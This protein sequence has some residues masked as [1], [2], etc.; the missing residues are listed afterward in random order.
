ML[1]KIFTIIMCAIVICLL[2][3]GT[4]AYEGK[5]IFVDGKSLDLNEYGREV[6]GETYVDIN[7]FCWDIGARWVAI[8]PNE[9][10]VRISVEDM[11]ISFHVDDPY[12]VA[13]GR[14]L[15][16]N[17]GCY[18]EGERVFLPLELLCR[19]FGWENTWDA[20]NCREAL[21]PTGQTLEA[22]DTYYDEEDL[23]WLSHIINAEAG[24]E[25]LEGKIAVGNVV[26]NRVESWMF[27]SSVYDVI[28]D[29]RCGVQFSPAYSGSVYYE[30]NEGSVIA[31]K[32]VLDGADT[33][34]ESLY[35]AAASIASSCWA[36]YNRP[37]IMQIGNHCFF[38]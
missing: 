36:A 17:H 30:P 7:R 2:P 11:E 28:F 13:N 22:G 23:Y 10:T 32:L 38:G 29:F 5:T 20:R 15:Y 18:V 31:A 8:H 21:M 33:A 34:G 1:K 26:L 19:I 6:E 27:P 9:G 12:I 24:S 25:C 37:Y 14:Y 3:I 35:F 16:L 4:A